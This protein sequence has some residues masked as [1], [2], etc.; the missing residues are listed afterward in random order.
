[1][2]ER[3]KADGHG[4]ERG[5]EALEIGE[6][7]RIARDVGGATE[8]SGGDGVGDCRVIEANDGTLL[9]PWG[10]GGRG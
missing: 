3:D 6:E 4:D 5:G 10:R 1:L 9:S 8:A 7:G 2:T